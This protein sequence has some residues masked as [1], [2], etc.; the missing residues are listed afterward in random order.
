MLNPLACVP[1]DAEI[2]YGLVRWI[3][4]GDTI[5][6]DILGQLHTVKYLGI[7]APGFVGTTEYR[8]PNSARYN[9]KLA[10]NQLVRLVRDGLDRDS[11]GQLLRYVFVGDLFLNYEMVRQ[12]LAFVVEKSENDCEKTFI[13]AEELA[14]QEVLGI[15]EATR[16]PHRTSTPT[17][18]L[19]VT[20]LPGTLLTSVST[21]QSTPTS[22]LTPIHSPSSTVSPT[23]TLTPTVTVTISPTPA[24]TETSTLTTTSH[25]HV[26]V[27]AFELVYDTY[28]NLEISKGAS[29]VIHLF[30]PYTS[31]TS[32]PNLAEQ[33][34]FT[35]D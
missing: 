23:P 20:I 30:D 14:K 27:T 9:E 18:T 21:D 15:W 17:R 16:T 19:T 24:L 12:G 25:I 28:E 2:E 13:Q 1:T 6:V 33:A 10:R 35:S 5:V 22:T 26:V 4:D 7:E 11:S 29:H 3:P 32:Y 31:F 8:G 34:C